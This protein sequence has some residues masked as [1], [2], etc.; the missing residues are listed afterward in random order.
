VAD[1][2]IIRPAIT[3]ADSAVVRGLCWAYRDYLLNLSSAHR[4]ITETFYPTDKYEMLMDGL[5][6]EHARPQ[7]IILLAEVNG[8]A[9][10]CGMTH[11]ID[12]QTSEIKRVFVSEAVRGQRIADRLCSALMD[13][14]R[15]DGFRKMVL[16]T[17]KDLTSA[18]RLYG[19]LGFTECAP[20]QP[21]PEHVLP[22]LVFYETKL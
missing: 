1:T 7:G 5:E 21:I 6:D 4:D 13:Q 14:A 19:R 11:P 22:Y 3:A 12:A 18:R 2:A 17:A 16:D 9:V 10:G 15:A 20:Y 8:V